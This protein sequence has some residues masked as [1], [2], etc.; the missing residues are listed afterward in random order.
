VTVQPQHPLLDTDATVRVPLV[1]EGHATAKGRW[2]QTGCT[3]LAPL[4]G[5]G[6]L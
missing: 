6:G 2:N 4:R 1:A 3:S 5:S